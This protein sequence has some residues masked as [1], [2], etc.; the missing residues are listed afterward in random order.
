[1]ITRKTIL[2]E[3][4][5]R[6]LA[7]MYEKAQ[8]SANIQEYID[9]IKNGE[10]DESVTPVHDRHF[11]CRNQFMYILNKYKEAFRCV[12]EWNSNIEFLVKCLEEGGYRDKWIRNSTDPHDGY[13]GAEK[14]P[15][16]KTI[17]GPEKA[18]EVINLINDLC[19]FYHFDRDEEIF[20]FNVALGCSPTSNAQVVRDYWKSQ[21]VNIEIDETE[22][23]ED[24]YWEIDEYG[25]L[26]KEEE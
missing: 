26:L 1:M 20:D 17:L 13:R 22:L 10:L 15:S 3:A 18:Q 7:E 25:H 4:I 16:L 2:G 5:D 6:C 23:T 24:E 9:K 21:G 19:N 14:T 11:L 8:P 12:N